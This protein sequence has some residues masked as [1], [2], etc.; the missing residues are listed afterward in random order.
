MIAFDLAGHNGWPKMSEFQQT[1]T[2]YHPIFHV[3][4]WG[5]GNS[6]HHML[7]VVKITRG[8]H[9][10]QGVWIEMLLHLLEQLHPK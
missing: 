6:L 10:K 9:S 5:W 1:L 8:P 4:G 7:D 3:N 2:L